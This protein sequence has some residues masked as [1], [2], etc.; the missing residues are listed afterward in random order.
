MTALGRLRSSPPI[1]RA[2]EEVDPRDAPRPPLCPHISQRVSG[3]VAQRTGIGEELCFVICHGAKLI[4]GT[5]RSSARRAAQESPKAALASRHRISLPPPS[6]LD[7][8]PVRC[9][10]PSGLHGCDGRFNRCPARLTPAA[11][12]YRSETRGDF[13]WREVRCYRVSKSEKRCRP[14]GLECRKRGAR[15]GVLG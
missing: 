13:R 12:P 3:R 1:I 2:G 14:R 4:L 5:L 15:R 8:L 10:H 9:L 11:G 7:L 6:W